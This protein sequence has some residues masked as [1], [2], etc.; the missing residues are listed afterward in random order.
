V[1]TLL[2]KLKYREDPSVLPGIAD[3]LSVYNMKEFDSCEYAVPVPLHVK[4]LRERG[5]NQSLLL[6]KL[7]S[8]GDLG[9]P[10]RT[11]IIVRAKHTVPQTSL[12]GSSRRKNLINAF[13]CNKINEVY[14]KVICLVDDVITTGTTVR[15]CSKI[16]RNSGA[17]E[18]RVISFAR[19]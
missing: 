2:Y 15:E 17:K 6:A 10:V 12:D 11:D 1:K 4:R 16:L 13:Y 18:V 3:I 8:K 9:I 14:G 5:I 7:I 19:A